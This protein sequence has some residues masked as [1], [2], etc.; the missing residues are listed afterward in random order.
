MLF[1]LIPC[2]LIIFISSC[3]SDIINELCRDG[4]HQSGDWHGRLEK[5]SSL[6]V[7][8]Q[9]IGLGMINKAKCIKVC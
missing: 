9:N 1:V 3:F 5:A 8:L 7:D 2:V 4:S 6:I